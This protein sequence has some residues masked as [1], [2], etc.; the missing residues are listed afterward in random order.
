MKEIKGYETSD[1]KKFFKQEEAACHETRLDADEKINIFLDKAKGIFREEL[2]E[3]DDIFY[4][5]ERGTLFWEGEEDI[6]DIHALTS[7][8]I[9]VALS[10][11]GKALKFMNYVARRLKKNEK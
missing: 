1:G 4:L 11:K 7:F 10:H 3:E 9:D 5:K 6:E 2:I 8:L